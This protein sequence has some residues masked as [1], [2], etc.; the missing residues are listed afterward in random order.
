ML[1]SCPYPPFWVYVPLGFQVSSSVSV[2][3]PKKEFRSFPR[4]KAKRTPRRRPSRRPNNFTLIRG[5]A[6][7]PYHWEAPDLKIV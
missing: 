6:Q 2:R 5:E 7:S 3:T 4:Q 1:I